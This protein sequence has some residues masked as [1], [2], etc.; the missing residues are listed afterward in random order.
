MK[1]GQQHRTEREQV[2]CDERFR[3]RRNR[4]GM[5][6]RIDPWDREKRR[7]V[8]HEKDIQ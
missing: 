6:G 8:I 1:R 7:P 3:K 5:A 4:G 2:W